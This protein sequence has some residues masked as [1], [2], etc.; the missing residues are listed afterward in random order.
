MIHTLALLL[1]KDTSGFNVFHSAQAFH[2]GCYRPPFSCP[3]SSWYGYVVLQRLLLQEKRARYSL[4]CCVL[5]CHKNK[6]KLIIHRSIK[7]WTRNWSDTITVKH[8]ALL[9][10]IFFLS[11]EWPRQNFSLL[12]L[13]NIMQTSD[14]NKK[15]INYGITNWSKTQILQTYMMRIICQTVRRITKEILRVKELRAGLLLP[16]VIWDI[17]CSFA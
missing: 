9:L 15:N 10:S 12:Y 8:E 2:S 11:R 4:Q 1:I 5:C 16:T 3:F 14:E 7:L 6:K 17:F 13:Y